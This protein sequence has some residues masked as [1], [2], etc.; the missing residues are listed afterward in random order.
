[1]LCSG[2]VT[3]TDK[4]SCK[5]KKIETPPLLYLAKYEALSLATWFSAKDSTVRFSVS[6]GGGVGGDEVS[7]IG[8]GA[9]DEAFSEGEEVGDETVCS[10]T[11]FLHFRYKVSARTP[12]C[13]LILL[14]SWLVQS[15]W[16]LLGEEGLGLVNKMTGK[17]S[18]NNESG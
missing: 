11:K 16:L 14:K 13:A 18:G 4:F 6:I 8:R 3:C 12:T 17:A 2:P 9:E 7:P 1:M 15:N 10:A 5:N